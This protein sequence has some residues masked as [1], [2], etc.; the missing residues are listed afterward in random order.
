MKNILIPLLIG[1]L[2]CISSF[3]ANAQEF[4]EHINKAFTLRAPVGSSVF[5]LYNING[6]VKVEG[7][8]GDKIEVDVD[9]T[10]SANDAA[11][12]EAGKN[13]FKLVFDQNSDSVIVYIADPY[14]SRPHSHDRRGWNEREIK[15]DFKLE[16][17][18]KV[19]SNINIVVST[20]ND[21]NV[22]VKD[23]SGFLDV[24]NI[25]G[26]IA[27]KNARGTTHASTINGDLTINYL[28][29]PAEAS[30]YYTL[31]GTLT[32]TYPPNLSADLEF[33]SMNGEFYTDFNNLEVLPARVT[34]NKTKEGSGTVYKLDKN[35]SVRIGS[36]GKTF[37]FETLNGNIYVKKQLL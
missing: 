4:K 5:A 10:I 6:S 3:I 8:S 33:K 29:V 19:P 12:L 18:V 2:I 32:A 17:T 28:S 27:I 14:D 16:F 36:G 20:I 15:Y 31:N 9:K 37:R 34:R 11:A 13:E 35:T 22:L 30:S 26:A 24:N 7:Y 25:N 21:G 1:C 23:V